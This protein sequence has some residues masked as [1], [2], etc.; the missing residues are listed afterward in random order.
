MDWYC[1][2]LKG[3]K[4]DHQSFPSVI[5]KHLKNSKETTRTSVTD[6]SEKEK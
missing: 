2:L 5:E 6:A 3:H 1:C 4:G